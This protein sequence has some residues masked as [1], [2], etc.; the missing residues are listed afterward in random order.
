MK[1]NITNMFL[2]LDLDGNL[3]INDRSTSDKKEKRGIQ[4]NFWKDII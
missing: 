3:M 1:E 2:L 4:T